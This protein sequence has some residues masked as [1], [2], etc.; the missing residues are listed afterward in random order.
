MKYLE[1][2]LNYN[3]EDK[4][5]AVLKNHWNY[6]REMWDPYSQLEKDYI[7]AE[8]AIA[9]PKYFQER[10]KL[11]GFVEMETVIDAGCSRGRW[12]LALADL[13]RKVMGIDINEDRIELCKMLINNHQKTN[14]S[15]NVGGLESL[16]YENNS[17]DGIFCYS[18]IMFTNINQTLSEFN[19]VLKPGGKLYLNYNNYGWY[20]HCLVNKGLLKGNLRNTVSYLKMFGQTALGK[21][22]DIVISNKFMDNQLRE[23]DFK[24][25]SRNAEGRIGNDNSDSKLPPLYK[26]K[27]YGLP[28]VVEIIAEKKL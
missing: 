5:K 2:D 9:P 8:L 22:K 25:M 28:A 4:F 16:P 6:T 20:L 18:V 14:V 3:V 12:S 13:N 10:L 11:I 7:F 23:N 17:A 15:F 27:F 21:K 24:L 1:T 26:E 19:R